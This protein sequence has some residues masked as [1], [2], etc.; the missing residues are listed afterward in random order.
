VTASLAAACAEVSKAAEQFGGSATIPWC[1]RELKPS[2][3]LWWPVRGDLALMKKVKA[4]M[5]PH[6]ILAP[7]RFLG[8]I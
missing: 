5:D 3:S 2:V 8:G 1:P 7:G 6:N 4:V